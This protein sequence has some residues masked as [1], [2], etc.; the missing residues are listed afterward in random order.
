MTKDQYYAMVRNLAL[1]PSNVKTV[2]LDR[3]NEP[4]TVPNADN[5]TSEQ[6]DEIMEQIKKRLRIGLPN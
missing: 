5:Y 3:D 2:Y 6:L 1:K 4:H